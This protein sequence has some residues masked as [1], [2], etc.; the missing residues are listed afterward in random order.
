MAD[1]N[2]RT[3]LFSD[4]PHVTT[5]QWESKIE[6]DLKG[7]DYEKRL[8]WRTLEGFNVRP[9]Y[10]AENLKDLPH[11]DILP[12][13]FPYIRSKNATAESSDIRQDIEVDKIREANE[14]A[15]NALEKGATAIGFI[16][17]DEAVSNQSDFDALINGID[18][19]KTSVHFVSGH[20][21]PDML[22]MLSNYVEKHN[23][24]K[25]KIKGSNDFD[26]LRFLT[27][28]GQFY[29][30]SEARAFERAKKVIE[31]GKTH[32]PNFRVL[33]VN[34]Q[35]FHNSGS[36]LV[37]ELAFGL[38]MGNEYLARLTEAGLSVDDIAQGMQFIFAVG[39]NYF[40]EIAKLRA[41]RMLWANI[42][43][44][45]K[46][47]SKEHA[48]INMHCVTSDWNKT[49]YD[50]Y[51]NILRTTTE[52][53]AS[54]IGGSDSLTVKPFDS[55]YKK[56]DAF[57]ERVARNIPIILKEESYF[58]QPIDPAAGSYYIEN[59]TNSIAE[60]AWKQFQKV[61]GM[62]GYVAAFRE[63]YIQ[64]EIETIA[65]KR[66]MNIAVRKENLIGTNQ[67]PNSEEKIKPK[68]DDKVL[69]S[70]N[71]PTAETDE[72]MIARPLKPYRGAEAFEEMRLKTEKSDK[73]PKVFLLTYGNAGMRRA[74]AMFSANFFACAGFE[75]QDNPG[76]TS[77][78]TGIEA[79]KK[80]QAD[81]VVICSSDDEYAEIAPPIFRELKDDSIVVVAGYPKKCLDDL[82]AE[83]IAHFVHI[84]S[85]ALQTLQAF[86]QELGI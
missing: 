80:S 34:A 20:A 44:A 53:M 83:G 57:S 75:I 30:D 66:D 16:V 27:L 68:I 4:F 69:N 63:D 76:F 6:A 5:E 17:N 26:P 37:Q 73:C 35:Y 43:N 86:Q 23:L 12:G 55:T 18:I 22:T 65:L 40:M 60:E 3:T 77:V 82:K 33:S 45:Y 84:K 24:D 39:S 29:Y 19:E 52:A 10:R 14:K 70:I 78:E 61:E 81:I 64:S 31:F 7:A 71:Q 38:T 56:S 58:D 72:N 62:G 47:E 49:I 48:K 8:V 28:N 2:K 25:N 79:A 41:A 59:L 1:N 36:S 32:L 42:V 50:P 85:N 46:P 9:Y 51:V 13:E 15:L 67:F 11:L 74:R 21:S 54:M